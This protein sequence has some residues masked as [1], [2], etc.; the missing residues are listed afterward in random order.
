[1]CTKL[2]ETSFCATGVPHV[3]R[4]RAVAAGTAA[5]AE[6]LEKRRKYNKWLCSSSSIF[7]RKS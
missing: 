3:F 6:T 2:N 5:A 1:M 7:N 4:L